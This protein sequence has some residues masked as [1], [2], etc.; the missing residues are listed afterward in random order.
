MNILKVTLLDEKL[1]KLK[2]VSRMGILSV[3]HLV[4]YIQNY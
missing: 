1:I 4:A 3:I 2:V